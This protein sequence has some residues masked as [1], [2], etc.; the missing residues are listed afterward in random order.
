M[1]ITSQ[2][3]AILLERIRTQECT[4]GSRLPSESNLA[5]ELGVS[6]PSVRSALGRLAGEGLL[7][8][9]QGDGTYVNLHINAIPAGMGAMGK[10]LQLYRT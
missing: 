3:N 6:P 9:K 10:F 2:V 1:P 7:I 8:R 4:P 5:G